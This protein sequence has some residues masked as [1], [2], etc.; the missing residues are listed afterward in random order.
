MLDADAFAK[1]RA[2]GIFNRDT[3][4]AFRQDILEKGGTED[5][6]V[7]YQRFRGNKPSIDALL[8]RNGIKKQD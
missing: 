5:P 4:A 8:T 1:F 6:D 2:D 3:A 7:L